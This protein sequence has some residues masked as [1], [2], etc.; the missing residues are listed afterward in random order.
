MKFWWDSFV[1]VIYLINRLP[2]PVLYRMSPFEKLYNQKP[3][4][5]FLKTFGCACFPYLRPYNAHK[6]HFRS[7]K[8]VFLGYSSSHKGYRC[9]ESNERIYIA[10]SVVFN[11]QEFSYESLF[12]SKSQQPQQPSQSIYQF[13]LLTSSIPSPVCPVPLVSHDNSQLN[14]Y[15]PTSS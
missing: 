15:S 6:F 12:L 11:E 14:S 1:T 9:L 8:C 13:P 10:K 4:Y 5:S 7:S 3:Y 2:T